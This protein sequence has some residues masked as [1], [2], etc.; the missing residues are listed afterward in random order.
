MAGDPDPDEAEAPG[1]GQAG[2]FWH[3]PLGIVTAADPA[4]NRVPVIHRVVV[5]CDSHRSVVA[6]MTGYRAPARRDDRRRGTCQACGKM[7]DVVIVN[8]DGEE[9]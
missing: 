4:D 5:I 8:G 6:R 9:L 1:G 2:N 3:D 7:A